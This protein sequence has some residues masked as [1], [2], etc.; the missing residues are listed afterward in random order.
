MKE[1]NKMFSRKSKRSKERRAAAPEPSESVQAPSGKR[2][3]LQVNEDFF[4][5]LGT[6]A[7]KLRQKVM[8]PLTREP[9]NEMRPLVRYVDAIW[10][11]LAAAGLEIQDHTNQPFDSGQSLD[12]LAFQPMTKLPREIVSETVKPTI[13][14]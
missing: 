4:L 12:V 9:R 10:D 7:W 2:V 11:S 14:L 8:D 3:V 1:F 5:E 6:A 13:Y